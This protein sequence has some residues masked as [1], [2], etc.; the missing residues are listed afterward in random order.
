LLSVRRSERPLII[1]VFIPNQGCPHL[2]IYCQQEKITD[3]AKTLVNGFHIKKTLDK[4][5][6]SR[7]FALSKERE[8]AFYG[9]TFTSLG[10]DRMSELLEATKPYLSQGIFRSI[11]VSTR[12]DEIDGKRLDLMKN[13]GVSTVELGVQSM[14]DEVLRLSQ[15]GHSA[16]DTV[17]AV[18][19]LKRHGFKVG[20]QLMPGLPGDSEENFLTTVNKIIKLQPDMARLYPAIVIDGTK[21]AAWYN[22]NRYRP[23]TLEDA[24]RICLESCIRLESRGIPVIRIGLMSSPS[25]LREGQIVAGP[26]HCAFGFL[27]R[28]NIHLKRI[29]PFLPKPGAASKIGIRAPHR[30][31][32]LIRGHKNEGLCLME[33]KIRAKI[34]YIK[35]DDSIPDGRIEVD[36]INKYPNPQGSV[37]G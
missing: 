28:S 19:L 20:A 9:G 5:I 35:P 30:E 32:P 7:Q 17:A 27:V 13:F 12:P 18:K 15:R 3:Q 26:W 34:A 31:I 29:E 4:A 2:C 33:K 10:V 37:L 23:L 24:V 8:I 36:V 22:D 16:A 6:K 11:R 25:L 21:L 14:D 1:P